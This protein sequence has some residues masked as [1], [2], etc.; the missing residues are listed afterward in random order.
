VA[1]GSLG[2]ATGWA[3][4]AGRREPGSPGQPAWPAWPA[5]LGWWALAAGAGY[6]AVR[7][8]FTSHLSYLWYVPHVLFW[9][10]VLVVSTRMLRA[11]P[12]TGATDA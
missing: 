12:A 10:W 7:I 2:L 5:W 9:A 1:L 8:A 4:L 11:R 3:I 6:L